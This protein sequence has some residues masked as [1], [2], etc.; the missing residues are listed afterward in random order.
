MFPLSSYIIDGVTTTGLTPVGDALKDES[1]GAYWCVGKGVDNY[2]SCR[3]RSD[4]P[5]WMDIRIIATHVRDSGS[6]V[7]VMGSESQDQE[8]FMILTRFVHTAF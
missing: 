4:S 1:K 3:M 6:A 8:I 5:L 7:R 2:W